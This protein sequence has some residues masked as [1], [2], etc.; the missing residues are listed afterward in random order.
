MDRITLSDALR[1]GD[2]EPF[3][4]Q[5]EADGLDAV[6]EGEFAARLAALIKAPPQEDQT[7]RSPARGGSPGK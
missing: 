7:S 4:Q 2:L 6:D 3:I 1:S 5:A